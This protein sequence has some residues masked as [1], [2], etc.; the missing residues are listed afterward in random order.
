M[1]LSQLILNPRS[2][3]VRRELAEPYEVHR[4][5][6]HA[7]PSP[8]GRVLFRVDTSRETGTP[9]VLIQ[10]PTVPDWSFLQGKGDYLAAPPQYK[11]FQPGF[12]VGQLLYFRLRANPTVKRDGKRHGLL[13]EEDQMAWLERKGHTGGFRICSAQLIPEGLLQGRKM[14]EDDRHTLTHLAV[15]FDGVLEVMDSERLVAALQAGIGS[16]K[17]FGFGLLSLKRVES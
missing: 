8:S 14:A 6:M 16:G 10:S 9:V 12:R 4:T 17:G 1:F 15:R 7:F 11:E 5:L 3:Q 13:K 2:P